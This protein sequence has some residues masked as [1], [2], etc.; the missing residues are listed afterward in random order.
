VSDGADTVYF[1]QSPTVYRYSVSTGS[2]VALANSGTIPPG[3]AGNETFNCSG[4]TC[5]FLFPSG[6]PSGLSLDAQGNLYIG[7][8]PGLASGLVGA[9]GRI[10]QIPAGSAPRG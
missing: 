7:D 6:E 9:R 1:I 3:Y 8:D 5:P 4:T 10:W 2:A